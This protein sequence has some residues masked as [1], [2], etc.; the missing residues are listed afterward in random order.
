[1]N[2]KLVMVG[3]ASWNSSPILAQIEASPV[4]GEIVRLG[5]VEEEDLPEIYNLA[6]LF[7][8][9]SLYEGFG[10]PILEAMACGCPVVCSNTS[11]LPEVA[12]DAA[13]LVDPTNVEEIADGI[14]R[15]LLDQALMSSLTNKGFQQ[16]SHFS[17]E[18]AA[19]ETLR[20]FEEVH[21]G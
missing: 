15:V 2:H 11:S 17:W 8:F 4:A 14:Q 21:D 19:R 5:Y 3:A 9:P 12:G 10:L 6:S 16:A 13:I 7:V 1:M 18:R 20:V